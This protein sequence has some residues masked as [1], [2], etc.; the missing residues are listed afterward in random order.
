MLGAGVMW[1][2]MFCVWAAK[3]GGCVSPVTL[4]TKRACEFALQQQI[5][6]AHASRVDW[7]DGIIMRGRCVGVPR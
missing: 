6:V 7:G 5:K 3:A 2:M 4:P 1:L